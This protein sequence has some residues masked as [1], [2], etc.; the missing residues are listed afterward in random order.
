[1]NNVLRFSLSVAIVAV[2]AMP[3]LGE[4]N[5]RSLE[6]RLKVVIDPPAGKIECEAVVKHPP[7]SRFYLHKGLEIHRVVVDG[8]PASFH[9]EPSSEPLPYTCGAAVV[10]DADVENELLIEYSGSLSEVIN[11]VN[12]VTP[13]LVEL[14]LYSS[15]YPQFQGNN[16]FDFT[17]DADL[18]S[19]FT[20][21]SN[22]V[23]EH[24]QDDENRSLTH[25]AS[26]GPSFDIVLLASPHLQ[27]ME[28]NIDGTKVE[29]YSSKAL[30]GY[31]KAK[32]DNMAK[33][34]RQL[35]GLYGAP[36]V[37]GLLRFVYSPRGGWGYSR[38]PLFVVSEKY[39]LSLMKEEFGEARDFH[40]GAHEL[41]HF[42]WAIADP[43]TP[44]D[45]IN[46]GLA[47]FSAFRLSEERFGKAFADTLIQEYRQ[48]A[49]DSRTSSPIAETETSS[50]DR[51][52]NRYE[53][54]ALMF[55][56]AQ[57]RFGQESTDKLLRSLCTR[58]AATRNATTELFLEEAETQMGKEA[59][60][61]FRNALYD[62]SGG[63]SAS[64]HPLSLRERAGQ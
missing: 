16:L 1:M 45:W 62:K 44:D 55:I 2:L 33:A 59:Q 63:L 27:E 24:R 19:G 15:W 52:V 9:R 17:L 61:F 37:K 8:N 50:P 53:K 28:E 43:N 25:W 58:F 34:M 12:M 6:Y 41:A 22:G 56:E 40:G 35:S 10:V 7:A 23:L 38:I 39:A 30:Q 11:G 18:P 4:E 3:L 36:R 26:F 49:K 54:V 57:R 14:A 20:A 31:M 5:H 60:A 48:H 13:D 51:Y 47:E 46:E 21:V 64:D 42:W 29:V 32:K